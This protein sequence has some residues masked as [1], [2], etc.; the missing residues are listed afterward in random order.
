MDQDGHMR[1]IRPMLPDCSDKTLWCME[2]DIRAW[3]D[4]GPYD[5]EC[6]QAEWAEFLGTVRMEIEKREKEE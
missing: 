1:E 2:R 5:H 4:R 3:I 6:Y